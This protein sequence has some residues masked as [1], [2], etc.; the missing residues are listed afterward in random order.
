MPEIKKSTVDVT[1]YIKLV[2]P[3]TGVPVTGLTMA[4][5]DVQYTRNRT[6]PVAKVDVVALATTAT[7]HTDNRM[8]EVDATSS[9][10]LHRVDWPDAAFASGVDK[11][12]LVVSGAAIDTAIEE[13]TLVDNVAGELA[14]D[15]ITASKYDETTAF[16]IKSTDT[17]NTALARTGADSDTLETLSDQVDLQ[18]TLAINTEGR[19]AELDAANIPADIAAIPTTA[20]RGTD[21][22]ALAS[23][24]TEGRLAELDAG[25]LPTDIAAIPTTAMR[26]TDSAATEAKQDIMQTAVDAIPTTAMRGTDNAALAAVATEGRLAELDAG[27]LPAGVAA[28]PTEAM[29]GTDNAALAAVATEGRLAE[30]DAGNLPT[31]IAA[32]PTTAMRGTD[33]AALATGLATHDGKLDTAQ[34]GI[35]TLLDRS[36]ADLFVNTATSPWELQWREK[37]TTNVLFKKAL[38]EA[39]GTAITTAAQ[40]IGRQTDSP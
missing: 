3:A 20:M 30:L 16:P 13:I 22:A 34:T 24:A 15:A 9:P 23:V 12:I 28:I 32:I 19:L 27:N 26:G 6:A 35:G 17:G 2:D 11:V 36:E 25:N 8:I 1:R 37:G 40:L 7:A 18:A 33:S 5:L 4:D 10:G 38:Y 14:D 21:N 29:R 31:D 39:D